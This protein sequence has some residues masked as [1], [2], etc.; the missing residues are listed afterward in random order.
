MEHDRFFVTNEVFLVLK[1][2]ANL[3]VNWG[4]PN[5]GM[6]VSHFFEPGQSNETASALAEMA[7]D[8]CALDLDD[9][10]NWTIGNPADTT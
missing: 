9:E 7:I 10:I 6:D 2:S 1:P 5:F 8:A 3:G 4:F